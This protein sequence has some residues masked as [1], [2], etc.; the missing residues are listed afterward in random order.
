[1]YEKLCLTPSP[2]QNYMD[3]DFKIQCKVWVSA[4]HSPNC[5]WHDKSWHVCYGTNYTSLT[6]ISAKVDPDEAKT[7][8]F[9]NCF[10]TLLVHLHSTSHDTSIMDSCN[11]SS[12]A[13]EKKQFLF[14][15]VVYRCKVNIPKKRFVLIWKFREQPCIDSKTRVAS[16]MGDTAIL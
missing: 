7:T 16:K 1:M 15:L 4:H 11:I 8:M 3:Y 13:C 2:F 14:K 9:F 12:L 5:N 6:P 10:N